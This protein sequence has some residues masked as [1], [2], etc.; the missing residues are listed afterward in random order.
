MHRVLEG[1]GVKEAIEYTYIAQNPDDAE[2]YYC[3]A[4]LYSV[5]EDA[6][7][8]FR[9]ISKAIELDPNYSEKVKTS[10]FFQ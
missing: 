8:A 6:D 3:L 1:S 5:S 10:S 2:A 9:F 4:C 7:K